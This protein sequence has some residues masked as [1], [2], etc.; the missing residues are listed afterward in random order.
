MK[1]VLVGNAPV[2]VS[3]GQ[4]VDSCDVIV[5]MNAFRLT[6]PIQQLVGTRTTDWMGRCPNL[7]RNY[8]HNKDL[9]ELKRII[10]T[11]KKQ[12]EVLKHDK[13]FTYIHP[14]KFGLPLVAPTLG[15]FAVV[16]YMRMG[17]LYLAGFGPSESCKE[18]HI[19]RHWDKQERW[20]VPRGNTDH[21]YDF[22]R[23]WINE[24]CR[25]GR[26][27]RLENGV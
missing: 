8:E 14:S 15:A 21:P 13:R 18:G 26:C 25:T 23:L 10:G 12:T 7:E 5:R 20:Q 4:F 1:I 16:H 3:V 6:R 17:I 9:P 24:L 27:I 11:G 19:H 22:E 2:R